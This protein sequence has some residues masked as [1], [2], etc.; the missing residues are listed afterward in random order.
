MSFLKPLKNQCGAIIALVVV[1]LAIGAPVLYTTGRYM[2]HRRADIENVA[3]KVNNGEAITDEEFERARTAFSDVARVG[4]AAAQFLNS[5]LPDGNIGA[6]TV[7]STVGG[8]IIDKIV[9]YGMS[10]TSG[11]ASPPPTAS[12]PLPADIRQQPPP[13]CTPHS[14]YNCTGR[15]SCVGAGGYWHSNNSCRIFPEP[16]CSEYDLSRCLTEAACAGVGGAWY[17]NRCNEEFLSCTATSL[18]LCFTESAC[19]AVG[20]HWY[21]GKC[22]QS[23]EDCYSGRPELCVNESDCLNADAF[24]YNNRCA[25]EPEFDLATVNIATPVSGIET[26]DNR[27]EVTASYTVSPGV[28]IS[29]TGFFVNGGFQHAPFTGDSFS[30]TAV[31][32]T[33]ENQI[34][35]TLTTS[36]GETYTSAPITVIS[37]ASNNRYHIRISWDKDDTDVDLHF[38][39][40]GGNECY[41]SN[42]APNWGSPETSPRLDVDDTNGYGPENITIDSLPGPGQYKIYVYYYSDHGNGGTNVTASVYENGVPIVSGAKHMTNHEYWILY[43]F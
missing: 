14:L 41:Y 3:D 9:D 43:E 29:S 42:K 23:H 36:T 10:E 1:I 17:N 37:N 8:V 16:G 20:G 2:E 7:A 35:A 40:S 27:I 22:N 12:R 24:W 5:A 15:S 26:T 31:L 25:A 18:N 13:V 38:S 11:G 33:G 21:D 6:D 34:A 28:S 4:G 32:V 39:W 19:T 30:T